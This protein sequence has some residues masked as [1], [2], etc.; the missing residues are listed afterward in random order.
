MLSPVFLK[1]VGAFNFSSFVIVVGVAFM[2]SNVMTFDHIFNLG[3]DFTGGT[4]ITIRFDESV[5]SVEQALRPIL[6]SAGHQ[7]HSIQTAGVGDI[8]IKNDDIINGL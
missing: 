5:D 3:I 8:V 7:K 6:I 2:V 4:S 1:N